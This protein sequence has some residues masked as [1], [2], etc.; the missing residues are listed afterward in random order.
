[1]GGILSKIGVISI[2]LVSLFVVGKAAN[3]V[4]RGEVSKTYTFDEEDDD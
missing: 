4:D 2:T 3:L 1:M